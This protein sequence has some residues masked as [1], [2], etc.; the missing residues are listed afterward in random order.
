MCITPLNDELSKENVF[1]DNEMQ[2]AFKNVG[3][4]SRLMKSGLKKRSGDSV[5]HLLYCLLIWPLIEKASLSAFCGKFIES[6]LVGKIGTLY[7]FLKRQDINW[8]KIAC[9]TAKEIASKQHLNHDE[10]ASFV[11][12]DSIKQRKGKYVE[13][14]SSHFDHTSRKHVMGHQMLQLVLS[15]DKGALPLDQQI[16]VS[17]KRVQERRTDFKDKRSAVAKDYESAINENKNEMFR[18]MITR[19]KKIGIYAKHVLADSWFGN[20][21]NI[22]AVINLGMIAI[23]AMRRGSTKY[24]FQGRMYTAKMLHGLIRRRMKTKVANRFLTYSLVVE[25]NLEENPNK[26]PRWQKV[27]LLFSKEKKCSKN[28]W[29][30]LLCTDLEYSN[31]KIIEIYSRRW[32][33]EVYFKEAKQNLGLLSNKSADYCTHYSSIHLTALRYMLLFNLMLDNGGFNFAQYRKKSAEA[34]EHITFASVLWDIFKCI[35]ND[36]LDTFSKVLGKKTVLNIKG[37][38]ASHVEEMLRKAL[39]IDEES[40]LDDLASEAFICD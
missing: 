34:L 16:Y 9:N 37:A 8:R 25:F 7:D 20:K 26:K 31:K 13:G 38:I 5:P 21:A 30:L 1:V 28:A 23:F 11:I 32:A 3:L 4:I 24:K 29:I 33:V 10:D 19:A 18:S 40:I 15:T 35:I 17:N 22:E 39:R 14:A 2:D 36:V 12:D 6:Y 27:K